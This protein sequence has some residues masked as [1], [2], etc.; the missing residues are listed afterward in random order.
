M[1]IPRKKKMK[2][3]HATIIR[4]IQDF[5]EKNPEQRFGQALH[6]LNI[7]QFA[8]QEDPSCANHNLRD[9]YNDSD[10]KIINRIKEI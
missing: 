9:I 5:L 2:L 4:K 8:N 7:N 10:S 6:N 1:R 3:E